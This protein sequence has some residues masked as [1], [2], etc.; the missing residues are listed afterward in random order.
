[1]PGLL[2]ETLS[3]SSSSSEISSSH[4]LSDCTEPVVKDMEYAAL[5][6]PGYSEKALS[7]QLEPIAVCGMGRLA[8]VLLDLD[9]HLLCSL[10]STWGR[11]LPSWVLGYDAQPTVVSHAKHLGVTA[12]KRNLKRTNSQGSKV[13]V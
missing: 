7:E 2:R 9:L 10:S 5:P 1:M 4:G 6:Y 8:L 13:K 3:S 11:Q 12:S